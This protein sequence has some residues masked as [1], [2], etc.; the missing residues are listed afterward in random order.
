LSLFSATGQA[1][2][3]LLPQAPFAPFKTLVKKA[4]YPAAKKYFMPSLTAGYHGFQTLF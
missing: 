3:R 4:G 2:S 1:A